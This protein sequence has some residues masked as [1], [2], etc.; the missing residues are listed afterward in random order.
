MKQTAQGNLKRLLLRRLDRMW[1]ELQGRGYFLLAFLKKNLQQRS[2]PARSYR[3][4][5]GNFDSGV[6]CSLQD[7]LALRE[8]ACAPVFLRTKTQPHDLASQLKSPFRGQGLEFDTVRRYQQGDEARHLD[9]RLMARTGK[10]YVKLFHE[11]REHAVCFLVDQ[12]KS[13]FFA[14]RQEFK[15]LKA[16]KATAWFAWLA[17]AHHKK[18]GAVLFNETHLQVLNCQLGEA[19]LLPLLLALTKIQELSLSASSISPAQEPALLKQV[20]Q[21]SRFVP[22]GGVSMIVSDF[23]CLSN[24]NDLSMRKLF[25]HRLFE[26]AKHSE[27][28]L[29]LIFDPFENTPLPEGRYSLSNGVAS[30]DMHFS[31][32]GIRAR[33]SQQ[34]QQLLQYL[35][36]VVKRLGLRAYALATDQDLSSALNEVLQLDAGQNNFKHCLSESAAT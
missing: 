31:T 2:K 12:S 26:L 21:F 25:E 29:I 33:H 7:L 36:T 4:S 20:Q 24:T 35:D 32:L 14:T 16:I 22:H 34:F 17:F 8:Q 10:P 15:S 11:E 30:L 13:L 27:V 3:R 5:Q 18:I 9:W 6:F 23:F 1:Q 19:G 28:F